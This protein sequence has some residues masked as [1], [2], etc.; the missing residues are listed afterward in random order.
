MKCAKIRFEIGILKLKKYKNLGEYFEK[1]IKIA[2][3]SFEKIKQ[4]QIIKEKIREN[5]IFLRENFIKCFGAK[6]EF[7]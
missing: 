6:S 1:K 5:K 4:K 7:Y 3:K 2:K